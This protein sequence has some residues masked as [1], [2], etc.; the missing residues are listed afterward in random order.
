MRLVYKKVDWMSAADKLAFCF[1]ILLYTGILI[2]VFFQDN[3]DSILFKNIFIPFTV[4]L[5]LYAGYRMLNRDKLY[6]VKTDF[7]KE[8]N[9]EIIS[10]FLQQEGFVISSEN[11]PYRII[12]KPHSFLN[13]CTFYIFLCNSDAI[14]F[15]IQR[16]YS[17]L[18]PPVLFKH[19]FMKARLKKYVMNYQL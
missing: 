10:C 16:Q 11:K 7:G 12:S 14:Y 6:F 1:F 4:C 13:G 5:L 18:S 3:S 9:E 15:N 2:M 8:R 17:K 19:L